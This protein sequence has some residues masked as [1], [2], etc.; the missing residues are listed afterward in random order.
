ERFRPQE[1]PAFID[2][3]GGEVSARYIEETESGYVKN[4]PE[5]VVL[6]YSLRPLVEDVKRRFA[7]GAKTG[8]RAAALGVIQG[9]YAERN[10][11]IWQD[12]IAL[13]YLGDDI[14]LGEAC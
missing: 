3:L 14:L 8:A 7:V 10:A 2:V 13:D 6:S 5:E 12:P 1:L 4:D 9:L 11:Q